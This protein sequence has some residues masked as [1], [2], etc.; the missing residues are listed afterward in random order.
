MK[1]LYDQYGSQNDAG[2]AVAKRVVSAIAPILQDVVDDG[3]PIQ[4]IELLIVREVINEAGE[5][6]LMNIIDNLERMS[7]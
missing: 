7:S 6:V 2:R 3:Y 1:T 5:A 4:E